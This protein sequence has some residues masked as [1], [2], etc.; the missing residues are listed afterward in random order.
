MASE[1]ADAQNI[2]LEMFMWGWGGGSVGKTLDV[3]ASGP[4]VCPQGLEKIW[5]GVVM[6]AC[7]PS[8]RGKETGGLGDLLAS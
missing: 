5:L 4:K 2:S 7:N 6:P 8:T 3:Q 1:L